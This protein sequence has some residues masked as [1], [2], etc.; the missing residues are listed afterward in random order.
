MMRG[1]PWPITLKNGVGCLHRQVGRSSTIMG[2][3]TQY[4][5]GIWSGLGT[6]EVGSN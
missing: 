5:E 2:T 6:G 1:S 3:L 4:H